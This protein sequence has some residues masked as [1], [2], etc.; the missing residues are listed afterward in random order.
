MY[1]SEYHQ[2]CRILGCWNS[3]DT[4]E[5]AIAYLGERKYLG[6]PESEI[7]QAYHYLK[8][9]HGVASVRPGQVWRR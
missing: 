9:R 3:G 1:I 6:I 2:V 7:R 8:K 4:V 5:E